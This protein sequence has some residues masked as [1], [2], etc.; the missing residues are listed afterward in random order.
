MKWSELRKIAERKGWYLVRNGANH[1]V[2]MH[3]E[4]TKD[5]ILYIAR[6]G[7]KEIAQGT[8]VKI[9]KQVGL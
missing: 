8:Y 9:K 3:P 4:R 2:Y 6:H 7:S 5:D 1:D